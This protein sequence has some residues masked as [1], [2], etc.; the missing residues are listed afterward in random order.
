M[1]ELDDL[2][3]AFADYPKPTVDQFL[4]PSTFKRSDSQPVIWTDDFLKRDLRSTDANELEPI[5][6]LAS[7][8]GLAYILPIWV[9]ET[10]NGNWD[11]GC[12]IYMCNDYITAATTLTPLLRAI[13]Q[14]Y[15]RSQKET[16]SRA[17]RS[18]AEMTHFEDVKLKLLAFSAELE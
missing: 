18:A 5:I 10:L 8:I 13:D 1:S 15:N 11:A 17:I 7:S 16:L 9:R 4:L 12:N 2:E 14:L 3:A 6:Y